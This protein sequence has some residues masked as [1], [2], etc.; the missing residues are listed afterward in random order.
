[1]KR[2][3]A[4]L[5]VMVFVVLAFASCGAKSLKGKTYEVTKVSVKLSKEAKENLEKLG[6][7]EEDAIKSVEAVYK[8]MKFVFSEKTENVPVVGWSIDGSKVTYAGVEYKYSS[9]KLVLEDKDTGTV[10]LTIKEV[11]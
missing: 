1:M 4:L 3:V 6:M 7:S 5:L 9:G 8:N 2:I 10:K 11:K